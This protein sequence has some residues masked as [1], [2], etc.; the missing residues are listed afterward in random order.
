MSERAMDGTQERGGALV[1]IASA[2]FLLLVA[3]LAGPIAPMGI[4]TALAGALT[5]AC[6]A[7][8]QGRTWPRTPV[9][10][11]ALGWFVALVIVSATALD[12]AGSFPRVAKGFMPLLV[13]L[14]AWHTADAKRGQRALAVYLAAFALVSAWGFVLWTMHGASF[15][16]RARGL[17][18]H[19]M[20]FAGQLL[21]F[22]PVA[23]G[24]A[25]QARSPRWR[26]AAAGVAL[27]AFAPLAATFTRS[28]WLG[29]FVACAV[30]LALTRPLGLALLAVLGAAAWFLAP[31]AW[32]ER[33]HSVADPANLW[34]RERVFMWDAG[35][36]MF[37]DHPFTGVGLQDL[38]ALY[39]QYRSPESAERAGHLHNA[40]IQ[41]AASM[42]LVGLAAFAWLYASLLRAAWAR[43]GAGSESTGLGAG[44][45]LGVTAA[46]VG[47]LVAG[48]FEWNFGDE[49]LLYHLYTLVGIAWASRGWSEPV[50]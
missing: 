12:R 8:G 42:G 11:A 48:L 24:I 39:D 50:A 37:R 19:Y 46:L 17:A 32:G 16:S 21:L 20:T 27:L 43:G 30:M 38:H 40:Y 9:D 34:N 26:W 15:A 3:A 13:G 25:I 7:F 23:L 49:E 6:F 18:G 29:L 44:V 5:L 33:L 28:A 36:R 35:V 1:A 45:R 10:R 22:I 4:T 41:I 2:A 47:F 31:G 14:A